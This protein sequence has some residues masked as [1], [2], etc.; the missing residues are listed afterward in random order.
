M[1]CAVHVAE[2]GLRDRQGK[3][4]SWY[5]DNNRGGVSL[6]TSRMSGS[7]KQT[8]YKLGT[9]AETADS[10]VSMAKS[11]TAAGCCHEDLALIESIS[12]LARIFSSR[13]QRV[14]RFRTIIWG[15][16]SA[17][18]TDHD[19]FERATSAGPKTS[20]FMSECLERETNDLG[21]EMIDN[22]EV[23]Q[24]FS[25][26]GK[27]TGVL[28]VDKKTRSPWRNGKGFYHLAGW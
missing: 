1:N 7:D 17:I 4:A 10:A 18:K 23:V 28:T 16:S 20:K 8:Y 3:H 26:G 2:F 22:Q 11:L 25:K 21:I 9:A 12:S 19:P 5:K 13:S 6:G 14:C 24:L 15:H 27:L